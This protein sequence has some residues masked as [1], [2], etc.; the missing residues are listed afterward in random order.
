MIG[1]HGR[2]LPFGDQD[3]HPVA[4]E[5]LG[6]GVHEAPIVEMIGH[7][8]VQVLQAGDAARRPRRL[9]IQNKHLV[10]PLPIPPA[11]PHL[12]STLADCP[13]P[14]VPLVNLELALHLVPARRL[15][16]DRHLE[17]DLRLVLGLLP[18][19]DRLQCRF[20][21]GTAIP[22][23]PPPESVLQPRTLLQNPLRKDLLASVHRLDLAATLLRLLAPLPHPPSLGQELH[24]PT[25]LGTS[26]LRL[27]ARED[28]YH[29]P[30]APLQA[31]V[32]GVLSATI[33]NH[34]RILLHG[35]QRLQ[36]VRL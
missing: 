18:E 15:V 27:L 13:L 5:D 30:V 6:V 24:D 20:P 34:A 35:E 21:T 23:G 1:L 26:A 7:A 8:E 11:S 9:E 36:A 10:E 2:D 17:L 25:P 28:M 16:Q 22:H 3:H 4:Q 31:E 32:D 19:Q 14:K 29:L 33:D 12:I